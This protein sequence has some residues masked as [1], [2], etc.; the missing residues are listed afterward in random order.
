VPLPRAFESVP[1]K[2]ARGN[3]D[4]DGHEV[5]VIAGTLAFL[6]EQ[7]IAAPDAGA[8]PAWQHLV[9]VA[10]DGRVVE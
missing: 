5:V 7:G 3:V 2:G 6:A 4:V 10:A 9:G 8:L 1:G